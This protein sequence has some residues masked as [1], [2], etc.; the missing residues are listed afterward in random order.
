MSV[1][2][3]ELGTGLIWI[4]DGR[5]S[6]VFDREPLD[7]NYHLYVQVTGSRIESFVQADSQKIHMLVRKIFKAKV[8]EDERQNMEVVS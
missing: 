1:R 4:I 6:V 2:Y 8:I 3:K 5:L 7:R